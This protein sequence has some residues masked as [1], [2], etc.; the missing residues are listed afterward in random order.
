MSSPDPSILLGRQ[1]WR[2]GGPLVLTYSFAED[3]LDAVGNHLA[4]GAWAAFTAAQEAAARQALAAWAAV[5]GL[6]FLEVP[7]FVGGAGI[8]LRFRLEAMSLGVLGTATGPGEGD[9]A[10]SLGLFRAD[11]LA[12][13][14]SRVGFAVLLHEIGHAIGLD[15]PDEVPGATRDLTVMADMRGVLPQPAAPRALDAAA[16]QSL[17]GTEAAEHAAGLAWAWADGAM[18]GTG[19]AGDDR[20]TGT[21]LPNLLLGGV[22]D[23]TLIGGAAND[24]LM[25]GPG[26]DSIAGGAGIDVLCL[27][28]RLADVVIDLSAGSIAA[29]D[30]TD[31][32]SGIEVIALQDGRL[33]MDADDPAARIAR[34]YHVAL[35]RAPDTTGLAHWTLALEHGA[36]AAAIA[37]G[38]LNSAEFA[39]RFGALDDAGFARLLA[40]HIGAPD[41]AW[42]V[43]DSLA[44]GAS[45]AEALVALADGF[46]A[47]RATA[48]N[49]SAGV[50][51]AA[52][53]AEEA[54]LLH[55]LA[56]GAAP[57]PED[58]DAS[59]MAL[60][61]GTPAASLAAAELERAGLSGLAPPVLVPL[62]LDHALGH[63]PGEA[64]TA[65]WLARAAALDAP[66]LLVAMAEELPETHWVTVSAEG[67]LFA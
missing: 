19:T 45:R 62:L 12:P 37:A 20:L 3:G 13:S 48:A 25:G 26:N 67:V 43:L 31:R 36:P 52:A 63:A 64:V 41:A 27:E 16:A 21:D 8:D 59:T 44:A 28:T 34:L 10:L 66:A 18:H 15:H 60:A 23:D 2:G 7:D 11:S 30:G 17:Y 9:I 5:S 35:D 50:W 39:A 4:D 14:P 32:F 22:G 24:T 49:L 40:G 55:R 56:F 29:P 42:E 38:F 57:T 1:P 58:W 54:A 33:V 53:G 47:R 6:S 61:A 46:A 65:S 51:D